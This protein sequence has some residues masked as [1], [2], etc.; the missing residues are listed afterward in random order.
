MPNPLESMLFPFA[1]TRLN[2]LQ[3]A[4]RH[5]HTVTVLT[6]IG[7]LSPSH[8]SLDS[9]VGDSFC[10]ERLLQEHD[11]KRSVGGWRRRRSHPPFFSVGEVDRWKPLHDDTV[12]RRRSCPRRWR[13]E[14]GF[15]LTGRNWPEG[16]V[17]MV[18][19]ATPI[20]RP[21]GRKNDKHV[22]AQEREGTI[23][24]VLCMYLLGLVTQRWFSERKVIS[25]NI[26]TCVNKIM[27]PGPWTPLFSRALCSLGGDTFL[28]P[29]VTMAL[30]WDWRQRAPKYYDTT[31]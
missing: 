24:H 16:A 17:P 5:S 3:E 28:Q 4:V 27:T 22:V 1:F 2:A 15:L 19:M 20:A 9:V 29:S 31:T 10:N 13:S 25:P 7:T 21:R 30:K 26:M 14:G 12:G 6:S 23:H 11:A 8:N 18:W